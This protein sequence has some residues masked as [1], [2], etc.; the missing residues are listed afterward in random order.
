MMSRS[1]KRPWPPPPSMITAVRLDPPLMDSW[2]T[3]KEWEVQPL[4]LR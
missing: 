4:G 3:L 1:E 2:A